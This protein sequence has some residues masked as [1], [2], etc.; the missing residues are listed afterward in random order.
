MVIKRSGGGNGYTRREIECIPKSIK[1]A[2][3][4]AMAPTEGEAPSSP[5]GGADGDGMHNAAGENGKPKQPTP[6][7]RAVDEEIVRGILSGTIATKRRDDTSSSASD[8]DSHIDITA[9]GSNGR[10]SPEESSGECFPEDERREEISDTEE[11]DGNPRPDPVGEDG[12]EV[13]PLKLGSVVI[14]GE[15]MENYEDITEAAAEVHEMEMDWERHQARKQ[16]DRRRRQTEAAAADGNGRSNVKRG[17][18][19]HKK[20]RA[21]GGDSSSGGREAWDED[22]VDQDYGARRRARVSG[23]LAGRSRG[24][25]DARRGS[26]AAGG[27][28]NANFAGRVRGRDRGSGGGGSGGGGERRGER[29]VASGRGGGGGG[30]R[31]GGGRGVAYSPTLPVRTT[32]YKWRT[33]IDGNSNGATAAAPAQHQQQQLKFRRGAGSQIPAESAGSITAPRDGGVG[34]AAPS[35]AGGEIRGFRARFGGGGTGGSQ[36]QTEP[37]RPKENGPGNPTAP[38][39]P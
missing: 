25:P 9:S 2:K 13:K 17:G 24:T 28:R 19:G 29:A 21:P 39:E 34:A 32:P 6:L 4:S 22:V 18:G 12:E 23:A 1:A 30:G 33:S 14:S 3:S 10:T 11:L 8:G 16:E 27:A 38:A 26:A 37:P 20:W 15:D 35:D 7:T 31:G 5:G 36:Q